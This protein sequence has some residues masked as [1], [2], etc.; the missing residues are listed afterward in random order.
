MTSTPIPGGT[1]DKG[2]EQ[3][4]TARREADSQR[5]ATSL[6]SSVAGGPEQPPGD[7]GGTRT[8]SGSNYGD[9]VPDKREPD[10]P[11]LRHPEELPLTPPPE[12]TSPLQGEF[13]RG[14]DDPL[15]K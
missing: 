3:E 7:D 5:D 2:E 10:H 12:G 14:D 15:V 13:E 9:W 11:D 1:P 6:Q 8:K 4:R